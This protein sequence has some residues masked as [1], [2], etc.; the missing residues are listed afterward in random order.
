MFRVLLF[1][2]SFFIITCY[3]LDSIWTIYETTFFMN[4]A[5]QVS[6]TKVQVHIDDKINRSSYR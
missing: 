3:Y 4:S 5:D 6:L 2:E 1:L